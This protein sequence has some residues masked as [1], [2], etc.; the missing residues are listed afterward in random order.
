MPYKNREKRRTYFSEWRNEKIAHGLCRD[1]PSEAIL[2]KTLCVSCMDKACEF[3]RKRNACIREE[4]FTIYGK[5][6]ECCGNSELLFLIIDHINGGGNKE[7]RSSFGSSWYRSLIK[8]FQATGARRTDL[9][10]LCY[11]CNMGRQRN[12]GVCP[13]AENSRVL[14]GAVAFRSII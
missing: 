13:H 5:S 1:C 4:V 3:S 11:N 8:E 10:T 7:V 9:R 2:G 6:C 12:G 14:S